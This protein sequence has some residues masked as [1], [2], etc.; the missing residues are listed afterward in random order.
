MNLTIRQEQ[1]C[2]WE[3]TS[4]LI[5][6]A[7]AHAEH[8]DG[9]EHILVQLLRTDSAFIPELSLIA[10][11]DGTAVGHILFTKLTIGTQTQLALAPLSVLPDYQRQGIGSALVLEGHRIAKKMGYGYSVVLGSD[12]YYG[13]FDYQPA[14]HFQIQCPFPGVPSKNYMAA[15]LSPNAPACFGMP[16]Y[17]QAFSKL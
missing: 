16:I 15:A 5:Q 17:A 4:V 12:T 6:T 10:E 7:F 3:N 9:N 1:P 2:D 14:S 8:R 11:A 13:R